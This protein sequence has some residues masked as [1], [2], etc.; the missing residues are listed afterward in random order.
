MEIMKKQYTKE[1]IKELTKDKMWISGIVRMN[2]SD[3]IDHDFEDFLDICSEELTDTYLLME[4]DYKV[5]GFD[6][7]KQELYMKIEGNPEEIIRLHYG[8]KDGDEDENG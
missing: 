2:V 7:E 3:L 5:V 8:D 4:I 6:E 1:Q